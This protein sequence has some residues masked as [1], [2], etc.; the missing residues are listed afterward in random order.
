MKTSSNPT[1]NITFPAFNSKAGW[2]SLEECT[3]F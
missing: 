1:S 2:V 3:A